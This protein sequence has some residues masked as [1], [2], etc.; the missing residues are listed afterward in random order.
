M[1]RN[2]LD[3][4]VPSLALPAS[5]GGAHRVPSLLCQAAALLDAA[6]QLLARPCSTTV[7]LPLPALLVVAARVLNADVDSGAPSS[8]DS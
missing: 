5:S 6:A 3:P 7:A 2:S 8:G 1:C 4:A